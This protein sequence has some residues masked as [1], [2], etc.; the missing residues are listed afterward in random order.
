MSDKIK[1][2]DNSINELGM[3]YDT[4]LKACEVFYT[5]DLDDIV[6]QRFLFGKICVYKDILSDLET[7]HDIIYETTEKNQ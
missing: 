4:L 2:I 3:K 1:M 7:L 5:G 6:Y